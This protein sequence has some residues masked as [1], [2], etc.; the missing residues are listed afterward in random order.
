MQYPNV[1]NY[2]TSAQEPN[3]YFQS[4][5]TIYLPLFRLEEFRKINIVPELFNF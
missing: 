2:N 4:I 3:C 1:G 5:F